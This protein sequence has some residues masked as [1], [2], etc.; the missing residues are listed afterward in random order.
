MEG[1]VERRGGARAGAGRPK[2]SFRSDRKPHQ[3]YANEA[4]WAII[5]AFVKEL[6]A[7]AKQKIE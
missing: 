3:I 6:R 5:Q 7:K 1:K 2:G 4:E